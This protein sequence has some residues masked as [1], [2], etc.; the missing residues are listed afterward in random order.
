MLT[1][2]PERVDDIHSLNEDFLRL[3][4]SADGGE[5]FGI[6]YDT[7]REIKELSPDMLAKIAAT[8]VLLF[9][10]KDANNTSVDCGSPQ[11]LP[12]L[13]ERVHVVARDFAREDV[14]LAVSYL[15]LNKEQCTQ[16]LRLNS[17]AI[18]ER[19]KSGILHI[20]PLGTTGFRM[21]GKLACPAER[22]QYVALAAND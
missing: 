1:I 3:V 17:S 9:R 4:S 7:F 6:D 16:L 10:I 14:G 12:D 15:G 13:M 22:T 11:G 8:D 21:L 5:G 19:S 18:R 20:I 2:A